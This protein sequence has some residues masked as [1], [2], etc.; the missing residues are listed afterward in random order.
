MRAFEMIEQE[1]GIIQKKSSF[2]ETEP[3][4][5]ESSELFLNAVLVINTTLSA[6]EVMQTLK[7]IEKTMGRVYQP[8]DGYLDRIIDLDIIDF[9]G[10]VINSPELVLPHPRMHMRLF[11]LNPLAE[12]DSEW[13][14]PGLKIGINEL[15]KRFVLD[16]P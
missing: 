16:T 8:Q 2:L 10:R 6:M 1:V 4:G 15:C 11:V 7:N 14:H 9:G 13:F 3:Q 12:I 5:Y